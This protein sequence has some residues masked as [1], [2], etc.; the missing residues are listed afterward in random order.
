MSNQ[1]LTMQMIT[2]EAVSMFKNS[3]SFLANMS[4]YEELFEQLPSVV[5][6][7]NLPTAIALGMAAAVIK[8]PTVSRRFLPW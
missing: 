4:Q 5:P 2:R 1:L 7:L 8:N 3:N 6:S